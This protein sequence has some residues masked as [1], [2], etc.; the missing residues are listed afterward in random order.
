MVLAGSASNTSPA[1]AAPS[2]KDTNL[3]IDT[4]ATGLSQPTS[5]AFLGLNDLLV[6][7]KNTG[8]V[9]RIKNN[10]VLPAH[11]LDLSVASD[12]ERGLLGIDVKRR[13]SS[14]TQF[15]VYLYYTAASSDGGSA[16]AN[17]LSQY[18]LTIDPRL[19]P[20]Q[21]RMSQV[22]TLLNLPASPG[23]NH[24]G[25]KVAIGP[26]SN[27]Y[28]VIGDLN[29]KTQAQN[30]ETG[31]AADGTGGIMRV[32]QAGSTV[33]SGILGSASP[34]N[35]YFAYGVRNSF[36][37]DFDP[38]TGRLWDTENGAGSADEINLVDPGFNSG[39]IDIMGFPQSGFNFNSLVN[40]GGKG[41]YSDPEFVWGEVVA[42]TAIEFLTSNK[43]GSAYQ[44]DMFVGDHNK[45][46]I[47]DFN[48]NSG[49]N[50]LVLSGVLADKVADPDS[51]TAQV[52]F[53]QGFNRIT[54]LKVGIGDGYLY[55]LSIGSGAVYKILPKTA[56][57]SSSEGM[58]VA[59]EQDSSA[60]GEKSK[61]SKKDKL[62]EIEKREQEIKEQAQ[63][64]LEKQQ[65]EQQE[66]EQEEREVEKQLDLQKEEQ[67][68]RA[69]TFNQT[70]SLQPRLE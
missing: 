65:R 12:S 45:G 10:V 58:S 35:K 63:N 25:G 52:V 8:L 21:G 14:T 3:R 57:A 27:V 30:F 61:M 44:N 9:K 40:F 16:S 51:E 22:G 19:G 11:L 38:V 28:T 69:D 56:A 1:F 70:M 2:V 6:L 66:L 43:L 18:I 55:V 32:T 49:R 33:G 59:S 54:D 47:Y 7:E 39:W 50:A 42:P 36:G 60:D 37:L 62:L 13:G 4:V 67:N 26:D 41:K 64:L 29:R 53:G 20:A 46:R 23:P 48:L 34:L 5:M 24:D 68:D 15:D 31:P 17:R